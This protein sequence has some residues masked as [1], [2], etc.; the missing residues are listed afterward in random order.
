MLDLWAQ[1]KDIVELLM[2]YQR[3]ECAR[4]PARQADA[5]R[6]MRERHQV[7]RMAL[8]QKVVYGVDVI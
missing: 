1:L 3:R 7:A 4:T 8:A 6:K 2:E 5:L